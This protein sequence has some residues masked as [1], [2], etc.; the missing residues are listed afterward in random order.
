MNRRFLAVA[1]FNADLEVAIRK[2]AARI[3]KREQI[4]LRDPSKA[5]E[6]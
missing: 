4:A 6:F 5:S 1:H 2:H 3:A